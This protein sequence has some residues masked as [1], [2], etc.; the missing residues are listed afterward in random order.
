MFK[1]MRLFYL[2]NLLFIYCDF[3]QYPFRH[4]QYYFL[5]YLWIVGIQFLRYPISLFTQILEILVGCNVECMDWNFPS[6]QFFHLNLCIVGWIIF[7]V[8]IF[9]IIALLMHNLSRCIRRSISYHYYLTY[10][11][12]FIYTIKYAFQC[13]ILCLS[14]CLFLF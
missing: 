3:L 7:V 11:L 14:R 5:I 13:L 12:L 10:I 8:P 2:F 9:R 6:L 1:F 4:K